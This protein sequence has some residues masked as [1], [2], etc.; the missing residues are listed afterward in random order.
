[1]GLRTRSFSELQPQ[2][3]GPPSPPLAGEQPSLAQPRIGDSLP[4]AHH[5]K[6]LTET[7]APGCWD[8]Q[9]NQ[10]LGWGQVSGDQTHPWPA[11]PTVLTGACLSVR[12]C[13]HTSV[14]ESRCTFAYLG[15]APAHA[16]VRGVHTQVCAQTQVCVCASTAHM[17]TCGCVPPRTAFV[18]LCALA[19]SRP[20]HLTMT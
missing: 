5:M 6:A 2:P 16:R 17:C 14:C 1:M 15:C 18:Y 9:E 13:V 4:R 20:V 11:L 3:Q 19:C 8:L 7:A 12:G 10:V